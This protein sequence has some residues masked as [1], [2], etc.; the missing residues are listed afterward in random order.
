MSGGRFEYRQ[1]HI[2]DI[3]AEIEDIIYHNGSDE[4]DEFNEPKHTDYPPDV[5]AEF[6]TAVQKLREAGIYAHRID[7][8][9]SGDD[10][11]GHFK[12]RLSDELKRE[13]ESG[14]KDR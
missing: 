7:W 13:E 3:A 6:R 5:I 12:L 1:D 2:F 8:L 9:L 4:R 14:G 11:I 10:G